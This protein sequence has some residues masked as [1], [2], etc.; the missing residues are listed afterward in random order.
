[1]DSFELN[2]IIGGF[3][4]VVFVIFSVSILS[5]TFFAAH[6]PE[7][8]G[9]AIEVPE[10]AEGGGGEEPAEESVLPLLASADAGAGEN[11]FKRCQAC[12][13]VEEG[14][15]NKVGPNLYDI[16]NR[17]S[18]RMK[19]SAIPQHCRNMHRVAKWSGI[20]TISTPSS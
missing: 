2:K 1:M 8:P 6:A 4:A 16:V 19:A 20:T 9:Y 15:A 10:Q 18:L 12:H 13:T 14:G 5:D 7:T 3:L 11:I 17:P